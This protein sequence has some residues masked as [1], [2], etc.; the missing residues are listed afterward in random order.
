MKKVLILGANGRI[1]RIVRS[2][3][4]AQHDV[5]LTL[6]LRNADRITV[7]NPN[8]ESIIEGDV[9]N[10]ALL[11]TAMVGQ[12]VVYA[13]LAGNMERMAAQIVNA[14]VQQHIHQLIW[15][16]GSGL[17][18]ETPEPFGS[19]VERTVGHVSKEDTRRAAKVIESSNLDYTIIRAAYMTDNPE[20]DYE[21][22]QKGESFKGTLVSR[23]SIADLVLK[24]IG[25]TNKYTRT[26]LGIAKPG[27]DN[28]LP[29]IKQMENKRI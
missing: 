11:D 24:V 8:R 4:L 16:T 3:L 14:M 6:F 25:S 7:S 5:Q 20:I 10:T 18:H 15:I 17:Y 1:A 9:N 12:D 21:L 22:T 19:W 23:A 2:R 26:S 13:N 27:T 28:S 29:L